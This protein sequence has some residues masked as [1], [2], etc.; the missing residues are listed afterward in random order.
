MKKSK[1]YI[2]GLAAMAAA[3]TIGGTWAVWTQQLLAKN[4]YMTAK[5]STLLEEE[6]E[7]PPT[8][9]PGEETKK[10]VWVKNE[11][12]IPIIA[13][14]TMNQDWIRREDVTA[15]VPPDNGGEPQ[16][17]VVAPKGQ[18]LPVTFQGEKGEEFAAVLNF[19]DDVVVLSDSRAKE[20]GLRLGI[21]EVKT[22][23]ETVGKWLL[24]TEE[25]DELGNFTFYYMGQVQPGES[26]PVLLSSVTMNPQL[27]TTVTG[28]YTYYVK[29][30]AAEGG[31]KQVTVDTVNSKYGYDS[32]HFSLDV[33]MQ[34]VQAQLP[35]DDFLNIL[36]WDRVTEYIAGYITDEVDYEAE[37]TKKLFFEERNG[38]MSYTPYRMENGEVEGGN[39]FMSFTNMVPGGKYRD[40]LEIENSSRKNFRVFMR[41]IP[42]DNQTE[43]QDELLKKI[44]MKVYYRDELIYDGDVTGY[45][46]SEANGTEDMQ[47][48]VPLGLYGH[49]A[50]EEIRVELQ[51]DP[52]L[53]LQDDGTYKYA[54]V[55]TKID[56][57]F[58]VQEAPGGGGRN[59]GGGGD[60]GGSGNPGDP[61][62]VIPDEPVPQG[63][64][65]N[66]GED[67]IPLA[68]LPEED[69]PLAALLPKTGDSRPIKLLG[70]LA[71]ASLL[72]LIGLGVE[73]RKE[74]QER[75]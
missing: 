14:I 44:A 45:H 62:I 15:L 50:K 22:L 58:M 66:I 17:Q 4:E 6:F 51:L 39:W 7:S 12:T 49:G 38:I 42:R 11:S 31:Y 72:L 70:I 29:N 37:T 5:Y 46:Y 57:E 64:L 20:P 33:N 59:P 26:T 53:G 18:I 41:I 25:P 55:L 1:I 30:D 13:K 71:A 60:G 40:K 47:G 48:L 24:L 32:S 56:W 69:V 21:R 34:T 67:P 52:N 9:L 28:T 74:K 75:R 35:P 2:A 61:G 16:L 63:G 68:V 73:L 10:A 43:L 8:W 3:A 65:T 54:D 27:E 36:H 23:D 19:T